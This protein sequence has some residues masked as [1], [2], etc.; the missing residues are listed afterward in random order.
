MAKV[1]TRCT[2]ARIGQEFLHENYE[3]IT[4]SSCCKNHEGSPVTSTVR[5]GN[6]L[7]HIIV[8]HVSRVYSDPRCNS[9]E[10]RKFV[11]LRVE[12]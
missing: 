3:K 2:R 8:S 4:K 10:K 11:R 5:L 12:E 1:L 7:V 9:P 6:N